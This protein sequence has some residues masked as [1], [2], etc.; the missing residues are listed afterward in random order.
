MRSNPCNH[1]FG[2]LTPKSYNMKG[3]AINEKCLQALEKT[4]DIQSGMLA[5]ALDIEESNV[6]RAVNEDGISVNS[7]RKVSAIRIFRV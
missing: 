5:D 6:L 2:V 4:V 7:W 1:D 3:Y